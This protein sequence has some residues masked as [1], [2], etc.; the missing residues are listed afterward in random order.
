MA[1]PSRMHTSTLLGLERVQ[2]IE[3]P[4]KRGPDIRGCTVIHKYKFKLF[5]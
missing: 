2:I 4:D 3:L 5:I 1:M